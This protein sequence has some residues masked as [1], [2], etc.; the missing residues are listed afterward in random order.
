MGALTPTSYL[1]AALLAVTS[2]AAC[3]GVEPGNALA[4]LQNSAKTHPLG[5]G[6]GGTFTANYSGIYNYNVTW[7]QA[8]CKIGLFSGNGTASFL[9]NSTESIDSR[10]CEGLTINQSFAR[11]TLTDASNSKNYIKL[12]MEQAFFPCFSPNYNTSSWK[13]RGGGG[14]FANASGSGTVTFTCT[15]Y[16][17][18][19]NSYSDKW[20]GKLTY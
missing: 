11:A 13:V 3:G 20:S 10:Y 15:H 14:K 2:L 18:K 16:T 9:G 12:G 1:L 19:Q 7:G 6:Q 17:D 5:K 8:N 4:P